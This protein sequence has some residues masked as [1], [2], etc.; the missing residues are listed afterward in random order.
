MMVCG[1][2]IESEM[3][4]ELDHW[5][6]RSLYQPLID[7]KLTLTNRIVMAPMTREFSPGG[8]PNPEAAGYYQR[9]ASG[10]AG[11]IITEG[12]S[13]PHPVA[14]LSTKVPHFYGDEALR[15]WKETAD[16]VHA[17]G[18]KIFPQLWH[19]GLGRHRSETPNPNEPSIGP[20]IVGRAPMREMTQA[21]IDAVIEAFASAAADAKKLGFDGVAIHGAHGYLI[22]TFFWQRTNRRSDRYGGDIPKRMRFGAELVAEIRNR[23]GREFPIMFRFSQWKGLHYD[24]KLATTPKELEDVLTPLVNA[25]VDIFDASTRRFW[26]PEFSG[27]DLNLAGWAKKITG[28]L[29]MAVGSVG[30]E[31]PVDGVRV[32]EM[33]KTAVSLDNL[34]VLE[35]ML[36]RGDFDLVGVGRILLANP[37]WPK[38]VQSGQFGGIQPYDPEK[39][40]A[41][42]EPS[43]I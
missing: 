34:K 15:R 29:T 14:H 42:L 40:V 30:L 41:A 18:G 1:G 21:D 39:T 17:A 33:S 35:Q 5:A 4:V 28:K 16:A 13:V 9:R 37:E 6:P 10:G 22:D 3:T 43:S 8:L 20:S 11:L 23:T 24:V 32:N 36:E 25:G 26:L 38:L 7:E 2:G 19:A 31:G 12:T 27:S